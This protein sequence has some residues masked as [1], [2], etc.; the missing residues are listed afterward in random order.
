MKSMIFYI[1]AIGLIFIFAGCISPEDTSANNNNP[2]DLN[3]NNSLDLND[4]EIAIDNP[5]NPSE[6]IKETDILEKITKEEFDN[7]QL[8]V[9]PV[10]NLNLNPQEECRELYKEDLI[11]LENC[12]FEAALELMDI[13]ICDSIE[14]DALKTS[15]IA[16]LS[17]DVSICDNADLQ[18]KD[19]C[20]KN[21]AVF[22]ENPLVCENI[23]NDLIKTDCI[24]QTS[25]DPDICNDLPNGFERD[26]CL[27]RIALQTNNAQLCPRNISNISIN[28]LAIIENNPSMCTMLDGDSEKDNCLLGIAT[29][30]YNPDLCS[31]LST[32]NAQTNC[33]ALF[34]NLDE[35]QPL[36]IEEKFVETQVVDEIIIAPPT[37]DTEPTDSDG[38]FS[39]PLEEPPME[40]L[41]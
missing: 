2:L 11:M 5:N 14:E 10:S 35:L 3:D 30:T 40:L 25:T 7:N 32:I 29:K 15:C 24:K 31:S 36:V 16:N 4:K 12:L 34:E 8:D 37:F 38:G 18:L 33:V 28:C 23:S 19:N 20:F 27:S 22:S 9:P 21:F 41:Q 13:S 39:M 6:L 17:G 26:E 1:F